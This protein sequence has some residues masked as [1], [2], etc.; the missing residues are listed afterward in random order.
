MN[1]MRRLSWVGLFLG[2]FL[3]STSLA[4]SQGSYKL[5]TAPLSASSEVPKPLQSA[6]QPQGQRL[7]DAK[8]APVSE[9]W[10][11]KSVPA[12]AG[13]NSGGDVLYSGLSMGEFVGIMHFPKAGSDF[14]GQSIKPGY[15]IMRYALIPQDGNHMGVSPNRDFVLLTPV[16]ADA[17]PAKAVGFNDLVKLSKQASGTNHPAVISLAA[18]TAQNFPS[19]GQDDQGHWMLQ[20]KL[21]TSS[22]ELP[23]ALILVGQAQS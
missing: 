1:P 22:G 2:I 21:P 16:S 9:I 10:F 7:V 11:S 4:R 14:R 12:Q 3:V 13:G 17:D 8:G 5:E 6:L 18:A 19:V 15:Y 20:V 23:F